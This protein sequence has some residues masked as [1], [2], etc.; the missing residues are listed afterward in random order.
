MPLYGRKYSTGPD[1]V[2]AP[3]FSLVFEF[4]NE[5][6]QLDSRCAKL[7]CFLLSLYE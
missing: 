1:P 4:I 6:I 2:I 7:A 5:K 3:P